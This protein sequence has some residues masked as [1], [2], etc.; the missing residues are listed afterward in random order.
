MRSVHHTESARTSN[1][2][3]DQFPVRYTDIVENDHAQRHKVYRIICFM[4][5]GLRVHIVM[6]S[7]FRCKKDRCTEC[8]VC[9]A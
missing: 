6:L 2:I 9:G 3:L 7:I 4:S 1:N 5:S 8:N